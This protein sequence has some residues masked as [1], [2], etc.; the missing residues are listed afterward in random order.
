M[1]QRQFKRRGRSVLGAALAVAVAMA[2]LATAAPTF[3]AIT[4]EFGNFAQC[5]VG[6][7]AVES[8]LYARSTS[9][10]FK[11]GSTAVPLSKPIVLQGGLTT[12]DAEGVSALGC[13]PQ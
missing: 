10:E 12:E 3:A 6:N 7:A 4:G 13:A 1:M 9:G 5:P 2:S 8:C 11:I